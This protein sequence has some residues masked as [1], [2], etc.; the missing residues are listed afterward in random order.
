[1]R[2]V[3]F[4]MQ[5]FVGND[6]ATPVLGSV[7]KLFRK[8]STTH[9]IAMP[10]IILGCCW[11]EGVV[12]AHMTV[13]VIYV[14]TFCGTPIHPKSSTARDTWVVIYVWMLSLITAKG[15][16]TPFCKNV[17][18]LVCSACFGHGLSTNGLYRA[19]GLS[20]GFPPVFHACSGFT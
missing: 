19:H 1:M 11:G 6:I 7:G 5:L 8:V 16:R 2:V 9:K 4:C 18:S 15:T 20:L 3:S 17:F 13:K 10:T 12:S 14:L